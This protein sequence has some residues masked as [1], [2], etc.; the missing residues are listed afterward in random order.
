MASHQ[1]QSWGS[2]GQLRDLD[3]VNPRQKMP[4]CALPLEVRRR[5][6]LDRGAA[7]PRQPDEELDIYKGA[8]H[9]E[10]KVG[11]SGAGT[12]W[13]NPNGH[14]FVRKGSGLPPTARV[15]RRQASGGYGGHAGVQMVRLPPE[16]GSGPP[17][18]SQSRSNSR[19]PSRES[20]R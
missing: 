2:A 7:V 3:Y 10:P 15:P 5:L 8:V 1:R 16:A 11:A 19:G 13:A 17:S 12:N 4:S 9:A 14:A 6:G 18:G 20:Q